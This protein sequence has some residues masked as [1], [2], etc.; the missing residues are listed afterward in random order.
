VRCMHAGRQR[1]HACH[2]LCPRVPLALG[3]CCLHYADTITYVSSDSLR[4]DVLLYTL[5]APVARA[6]C[7]QNRSGPKIQAAELPKFSLQG[8]DLFLLESC[9]LD[10]LRGLLFAGSRIGFALAR[11]SLRSLV[12]GE[13]V[14]GRC[15]PFFLFR[16]G[17][18]MQ[19]SKWACRG[20][21]ERLYS[22]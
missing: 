15:P 14:G 6:A 3:T 17:K 22:G 2:C 13:P 9:A 7:L 1:R 10:V 11:L 20:A 8:E 18:F 16:G 12:R 5:S 19:D 4:G 21:A